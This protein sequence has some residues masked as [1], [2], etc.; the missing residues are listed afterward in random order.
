MS[1]ADVAKVDANAKA[2]APNPSEASD[3]SKINTP[4]INVKRGIGKTFAI[5]IAMYQH[6]SLIQQAIRDA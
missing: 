6:V 5:V 2:D 3:G 1:D 4:K